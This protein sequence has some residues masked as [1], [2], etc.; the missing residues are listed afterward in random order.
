MS[1][2][3]L[4]LFPKKSKPTISMTNSEAKW[5]VSGSL[6]V[7]LTIALGIN[8]TLFSQSQGGLKTMAGEPA[9][10]ARSIASINPIFRVSW[11]KKAFQVLEN[12]QEREIANVGQKPSAYDSFAFGALEGKYQIRK[13]DGL[14][15]EVQFSQ[16]A[17]GAPK[18]LL[19]RESFLNSNIALFS[20]DA[21]RAER[22]R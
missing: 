12:T 11:E 1:K 9:S 8:A 20:P 5:M 22:V 16:E 17:Q 21:H 4:I 3:N 13:I 10:S 6:L 18:A 15:S 14:I 2:D 7:I 19:E